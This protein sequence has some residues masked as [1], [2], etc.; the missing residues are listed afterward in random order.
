MNR[1]WCAG[2]LS[3]AAFWSA[4]LVPV[5]RAEAGDQA[6]RK[7]LWRA[8]MAAPSHS[9]PAESDGLVFVLSE[10]IAETAQP[11]RLNC[12]NAG[13]GKLEWKT[14]LDHFSAMPP[15]KGAKGR[16]MW[17]SYCR[18]FKASR[19]WMAGVRAIEE[20]L[21]ADPAE[22][23]AGKE[24]RVLRSELAYAF[25]TAFRSLGNAR[26]LPRDPELAEGWKK[27]TAEAQK[28][29][30]SLPPANR[31]PGGRG[32]LHPGYHAHY[33]RD[34]PEYSVEFLDDELSIGLTWATPAV[35]DDGVYVSTANDF[36]AAYDRKGEQ[37]W[38]VWDPWRGNKVGVTQTERLAATVLCGDVLLVTGGR[39]ARNRIRI[40]AY[41]RKT[42]DKLWESKYWHGSFFGGMLVPLKLEHMD[43]VLT[44]G[45]WVYRV[46]DGRPLV[47]WP[48]ASDWP[49]GPAAA[50]RISDEA[51]EKIGK[52]FKLPKCLHGDQAPAV[53]GNVL[54]YICNGD[55]DSKRT[56]LVLALKLESESDEKLKPGLVWY[57]GD[58]PAMTGLR[59]ECKYHGTRSI[60][61]DGSRVYYVLERQALH[62]RD[63]ATGELVAEVPV[64]ASE[65]VFP[66]TGYPRDYAGTSVLVGNRLLYRMCDGGMLVF[67][68]GKKPSQ[69]AA[70]SL[71]CRWQEEG[72]PGNDSEPFR[73]LG[74]E[75]Y[76][77][78]S[79]PTVSGD[80]VF[81]R[82]F[83]SIYCLTLK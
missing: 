56:P 43:V 27:L 78:H 71:R 6:W 2:F 67:E 13:T 7:V 64:K 38:A 20:K 47:G 35:D 41:S 8:D 40:R 83:D 42:G 66:K 37:R 60:L 19:D 82:T 80:K 55:G 52:G 15:E 29:G 68:L 81:I 28:S 65:F 33:L 72:K 11:A 36:V 69:L 34:L 75:S 9:S 63:A 57:K 26:T 31:Q 58:V 50:P 70:G 21:L 4:V 10:P 62:V 59:D 79:R 32:A 73:R 16:E 48:L 1:E 14:D 76:P 23:V 53:R 30:F 46:K 44:Q 3:A 54:Y 18:L 25:N 17:K 77:G 12:F 51:R 61:C 74:G 39:A 45:G 49:V 22:S 5:S 24:K